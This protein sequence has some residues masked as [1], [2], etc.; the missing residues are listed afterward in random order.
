MDCGHL[1]DLDFADDITFLSPTHTQMQDK[2]NT[3]DQMSQKLR[4]S[5]HKGKIMRINHKR[6]NRS[7]WVIP[8]YKR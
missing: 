1:N 4:L 8:H 5:I 3:F 6:L 7:H 2:Q